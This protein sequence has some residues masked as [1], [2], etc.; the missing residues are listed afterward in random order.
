M[1]TGKR[2]AGVLY[3]HM[4]A[5]ATLSPEL[6]ASVATAIKQIP[7][8]FQAVI[9]AIGKDFIRFAE[10]PEWNLKFEP[11]V[12]N[13]FCVFGD[14]RTKLT[15]AS[16]DNPQIYHRRHLFVLP[17]YKGFSVESDVER[18]KRW[19]HLSPNPRLMGRRKWWDA[20]CAKNLLAS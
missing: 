12:G 15:K 13:S 11:S 17:D 7:Q 14:G 5:L 9:V 4:S 1:M 6:E 10:C 2:I 20:F 3:I 19:E 18:V 16:K 8:G